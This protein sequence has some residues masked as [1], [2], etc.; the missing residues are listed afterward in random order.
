MTKNDFYS[1]S[2]AV[3]KAIDQVFCFAK[4]NFTPGDFLLFLAGADK[5][6][7][8]SHNEIPYVYD[9]QV[10]DLNMSSRIQ[11]LEMYFNSNY[12]QHSFPTKDTPISL[13]FELLL[14]MQIW[15]EKSF[16]KKLHRLA[17]LCN[18]NQYDWAVKIPPVGMHKF[19]SPCTTTFE[20]NK[21]DF[22]SLIRQSYLSQIRDAAA[23]DEYRL[24][25]DSIVFLNFNNKSYQIEM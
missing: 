13:T 21:L 10:Y 25:H 17:S 2:N 18:G 5:N 23:H 11:F 15:G 6:D 9:Y 12:A 24:S 16:L 1:I 20:K 3:A 22:A 14:Y 7:T 19:I 8:I 4:K